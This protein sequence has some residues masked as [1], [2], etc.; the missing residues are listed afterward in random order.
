MPFSLPVIWAVTLLI[1]LLNALGTKIF[2]REFYLECSV[3][4]LTLNTWFML[5]VM[6]TV[7][8]F[9]NRIAR[10]SDPFY[11]YVT[12]LMVCAVVSGVSAALITNF[13]WRFDYATNLEF[14]YWPGFTMT[15]T[16]HFGKGLV[17]V[18]TAT[19]M[20]LACRHFR[21]LRWL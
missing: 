5:G 4:E 7:V 2:L 14:G 19:G 17:M 20:L 11:F 1:A 18:S 8:A 16:L 21:L 12:A 6:L 9:I 3:L 15:F 10:L 13:P